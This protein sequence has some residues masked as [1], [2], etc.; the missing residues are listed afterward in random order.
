VGC[1]GGVTYPE[2]MGMVLDSLKALD[3]SSVRLD[4]S[5]G[6]ILDDLTSL[7]EILRLARE[8]EFRVYIN[9]HEHGRFGMSDATSDFLCTEAGVGARI[10]NESN[11]PQQVPCINNHSWRAYFLHHVHLL[12]TSHPAVIW[13]EDPGFYP[14]HCLS[15]SNPRAAAA[16]VQQGENAA[17]SRSVASASVGFQ[18][19]DEAAAAKI[20][21]ASM[22]SFV[23][24]AASVASQQSTTRECDVSLADPSHGAEW[25]FSAAASSI[26]QVSDGASRALPQQQG[27]GSIKRTRF[28]SRMS[29]GLDWVGEVLE[30]GTIVVPLRLATP[31]FDSAGQTEYNPRPTIEAAVKAAVETTAGAREARLRAGGTPLRVFLAVEVEAHSADATDITSMGHTLAELYEELGRGTFAF[32][33][34]MLPSLHPSAHDAAAAALAPKTRR[35]AVTLAAAIRGLDLQALG[36][37][38]L[39]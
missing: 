35:A 29:V 8:L 33:G 5:E 19:G 32:H 14:C 4:I 36:N 11:D 21:Q 24:T 2:L 25:G 22:K 31:V 26:V 16:L 30:V 28:A 1:L 6:Q 18:A 23:S 9:L 20:A 10:V 15:C 39:C 38:A 17:G 34:V 7:R 3:I 27:E 37:V 12:S 13:F